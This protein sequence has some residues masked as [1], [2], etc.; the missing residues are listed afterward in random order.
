MPPNEW[1]QCVVSCTA[2]SL[3]CVAVFEC[4]FVYSAVLRLSELSRCYYFQWEFTASDY[5]G[6]RRDL[7]NLVQSLKNL[8]W[9][10]CT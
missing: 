6:T 5:F 10:A 4:V 8:L 9:C 7:S 1:L 2:Y 3:I